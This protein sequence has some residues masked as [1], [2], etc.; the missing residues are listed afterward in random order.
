ML[1]DQSA[2]EPGWLGGEKDG[3]TGWF[4]EAYIE[5]IDSNQIRYECLPI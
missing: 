1:A 3:K 5:K 2:A 4:P